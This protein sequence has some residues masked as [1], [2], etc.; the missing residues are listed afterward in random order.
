MKPELFTIE[1]IIEH[2]LSGANL[3]DDK[4]KKLFHFPLKT[5]FTPLKN[6]D[7]VCKN[8]GEITLNGRNSIHNVVRY[9]RSHSVHKT[10]FKRRICF[11]QIPT[12]CS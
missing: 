2:K 12:S 10:M 8:T 1:E 11:N 6:L 5:Q 4:E 3:S 7:F 9:T